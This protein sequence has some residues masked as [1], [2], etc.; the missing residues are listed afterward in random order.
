MLRS[1]RWY[2]G[3]GLRAFSHRTRTRQLGIGGPEHLGKPVIAIVNTW[4][5]LNPCHSHL[6]ERAEAVKRGVWQAGG[7]PV[8]LPAGSMGGETFQ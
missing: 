6:R 3:D 4:T 5:E 7:Y 8:E 1:Q 2:E